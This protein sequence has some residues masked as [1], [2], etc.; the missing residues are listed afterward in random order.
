MTHH[1]IHTSIKIAGKAF[2]IKLEENHIIIIGKTDSNSTKYLYTTHTQ[3][4]HC[5]A[6]TQHK[7]ILKSWIYTYTHMKPKYKLKLHLQINQNFTGGAVY[8]KI[9]K[10]S[11]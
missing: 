5:S 6:L 2:I 4:I 7:K 10:K 3:Y 1:M 11:F 8:N 9:K